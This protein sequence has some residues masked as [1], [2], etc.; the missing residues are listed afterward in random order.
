MQVAGPPPSSA[1]QGRIDKLHE[2]A[3]TYRRKVSLTTDQHCHT[4][5]R[6]LLFSQHVGEQHVL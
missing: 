2:L 5:A 3:D 1:Q 6:C 4:F